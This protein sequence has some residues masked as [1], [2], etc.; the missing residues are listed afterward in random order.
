MPAFDYQAQD[1]NGRTCRGQQEADSARHARQILRERGLRITRL[2]GA[3]KSRPGGRH[4]QAGTRL[5]VT[6]LALLTR[7]L[8]TLIHA[9]LPL[10]EALAA[11]TA[12]SE[13]TAVSKVLAAVRNRVTEGHALA[14]ALSA[15]PRAFPELFR[16]TVAAGERSGH[17]GHVLEQ[18]ADY[19][20]ARQASRQKIQLALVYPMILMF[21][22]VAIV[23]FL[24][25][26]VV[27]DVVKIFINSGQP[28][29]PLTQAM[30]AMSNGLRRYGWL[31][32][33]LLM[34]GTGAARWALRQPRL[35]LRW[36]VLQL[37][38]PLVGPVLRAMEAAR[39]ASTLAILG[40]SAVPLVDA[41]EISATVIANLAIRQ[42]MLDVARSVREGG[43]L[44]RGLERSGDIPPMMLHLIASGERAGEL[45]SMLAR[46]AE[47]QEKNLAARIALVVSLFEPIM[48]VLMGGVVLLIVMAILLPILSL[49]Q[50]VN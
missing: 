4:G 22:S 7:Q 9:G 48:L 40:K 33:M 13:K 15:F 34:A 45:D 37:N 29:P 42:R 5:G 24:L 16:A 25:G 38:L 3:K 50:L 44:A 23:G 31:L 35:K 18:L 14:T 12:Q 39:F 6:D 20:E 46:A 26:Y 41:L 1:A 28:L 36:H 32:L 27:P 47:Q 10:E 49:N 8:A 43:T 19:T 2:S 21:A 30:M 11:V 17:L